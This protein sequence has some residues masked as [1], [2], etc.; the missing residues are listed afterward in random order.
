MYS[1]EEIYSQAIRD[2]L[3]IYQELKNKIIVINYGYKMQ[4][5]KEKIEILNCSKGGDYFVECNDQEYLNFYTRGW[6]KG[7]I[8]NNLENC[9]RKLEIIEE[10]VK[11]EINTRKNDKYIQHLKNRRE[12]ILNKYTNL[13]NKLN[14]KK[15]K[16]F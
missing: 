1:L 11:M 8:L 9:K 12:S 5:F 4:K 2:K 16:H 14:G 6:R 15:E 13:K 7:C 3:G 10:K